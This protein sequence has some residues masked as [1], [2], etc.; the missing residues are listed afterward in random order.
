[1]RMSIRDTGHDMNG[2]RGTK[3]AVLLGEDGSELKTPN[4]V[5]DASNSYA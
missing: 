1:M 2:Q 4:A 3:S 5:Q